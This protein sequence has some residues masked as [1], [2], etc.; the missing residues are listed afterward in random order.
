VAVVLGGY[1][2]GGSC[3]D[4]CNPTDIMSWFVIN[5]S[6]ME[7]LCYELEDALLWVEDA[8]LW[9][10]YIMKMLCYGLFIYL[11]TILLQAVA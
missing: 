6:I 11:T 7:M 1:C 2:P 3:K 9:V 4:G 8:L 10:I 5:R